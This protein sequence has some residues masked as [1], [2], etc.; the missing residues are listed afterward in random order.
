MRH[1]LMG[2]CPGTC[3]TYLPL[4]NTTFT[5]ALLSVVNRVGHKEILLPCGHFPKQQL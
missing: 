1:K 4:R 3:H 5:K 2:I